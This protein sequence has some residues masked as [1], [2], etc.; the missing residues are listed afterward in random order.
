M[1]NENKEMMKNL[2]KIKKGIPITRK[3]RDYWIQGWQVNKC[4]R[5]DWDEIKDTFEYYGVDLN[6]QSP[7]MTTQTLKQVRL[8]K[9]L[10][11]IIKKDKEIRKMASG[12]SFPLKSVYSSE[13]YDHEKKIEGTIFIILLRIIPQFCLELGRQQFENYITNGNPKNNLNEMFSLHGTIF[14]TQKDAENIIQKMI[15]EIKKGVKKP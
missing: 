10:T 15:D 8:A 14:E 6:R 5:P 3:M 12:C 7:I 2:E 4:Y 11:E 13:D 9:Q 1:S